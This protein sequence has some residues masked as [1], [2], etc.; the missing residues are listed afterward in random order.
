MIKKS[1]ADILGNDIAYDIFVIAG[2]SNAEGNG[3]SIKT[4]LFPFYRTDNDIK[5]FKHIQ[6]ITWKKV[7]SGRKISVIKFTNFFRFKNAAPF[8][9]ANYGFSLFLLIYTKRNALKR[10]EKYYY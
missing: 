7:S 9:P 6:H 3:R 2:Q 10:V 4:S 5:M 8:R 1:I